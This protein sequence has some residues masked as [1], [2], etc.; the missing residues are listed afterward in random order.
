[1]VPPPVA[2]PQYSYHLSV[3]GTNYGPYTTSQLQ[4][5]VQTGQV[6]RDS[7]LWREGM[8]AWLGAGQIAELAHLFPDDWPVQPKGRD[9]GDDQPPSDD[10]DLSGESM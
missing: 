4:Q 7:L 8:A 5:Y 9:T 6:T 3:A 10:Q 2:A 1:M